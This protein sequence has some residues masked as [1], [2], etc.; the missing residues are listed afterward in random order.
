MEGLHQSE[1]QDSLDKK[2]NRK[3]RKNT[4]VKIARIPSNTIERVIKQP[5][6]HIKLWRQLIGEEPDGKAE[7]LVK[8]RKT[9]TKNS[10]VPESVNQEAY[11]NNPTEAHTIHGGLQLER[12][13]HVLLNAPETG[14]KELHDQITEQQQTIEAARPQSIVEYVATVSREEL[15]DISSKITVDGTSLRQAY[16]T[17]LIGENAL[18]RLVAEHV[19]GGNLHDALRAEIMQ[20]EID[21]ERDPQMR[22]HANQ[23]ISTTKDDDQDQPVKQQL[24]LPVEAKTDTTTADSPKPNTVS[25]PYSE[26]TYPNSRSHTLDLVLAGVIAVLVA[27]VVF[28]LI[29]RH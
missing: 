5:G 4:E 23:Q 11:R 25:E 14:H 28:L 8:Q 24:P 3:W 29:R 13:G 21:F 16:E 15:M 18:R 1:T 26:P 19:R 20:H 6:E 2:V 7:A 12:I 22:D 10:H 9:E 17:H 27:C